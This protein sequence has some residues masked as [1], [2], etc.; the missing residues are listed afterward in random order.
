MSLEVLDR[1]SEALFEFLWCFVC[2]QEVFTHI[3]FKGVFYKNCNTRV[4]LQESRET[5]S[6]GE[7]VLACFDTATTWNL[8]V[9][10]KPQ[11]PGRTGARGNPRCTGRVRGC[12]FAG[13]RCRRNTPVVID[14]DA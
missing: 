8:H 12:C 1:H 14:V 5:R 13:D 7:A 3:P 4:E 2:G 10:E 6:Y 9:D 11:P